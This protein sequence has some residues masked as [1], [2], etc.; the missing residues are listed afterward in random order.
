MPARV[1]RALTIALAL[2]QVSC[3]GGDSPSG[4]TPP[5]STD[6]VATTLQILAGNNQETGPGSDVAVAPSIIV[7]DQ[8]GQPFAGA[9]VTFSVDLGGGS[10]EGATV[11][12]GQNGVASVASWTLGGLLGAN[13][14][15]AS[16]GSIAPVLFNATA[17]L[18][19]ASST[20]SGSVSLPAGSSLSLGSLKVETGVTVVPVAAT[21]NFTTVAI[22]GGVHFAS[23]IAA[24]GNTVLMGWIDGSQPNFSARTTAEVMVYFDMGAFMT[25]DHRA[26]SA[27][28]SS[29]SARNDLTPLVNAI[30]QALTAGPSSVTLATTAVQ[31]ARLALAQAAIAQQPPPPSRAV[32]INGG[33]RSGI[34]VDQV[35][36]NNIIITNTYRRRVAAFVDRVSYVPE[37]GGD[38]VPSPLPGNKI[39]LSAVTSATSIIGTATDIAVG[40]MAWVPVVTEPPVPTPVFPVNARST[41]YRVTVLGPGVRN[42]NVTMNADQVAAWRRASAETAIHEFLLPLLDQVLMVDGELH[43]AGKAPIPESIL[44]SII[45]VMPN[46]V[47]ENF[48]K[49]NVKEGVIEMI[50]ALLG[51]GAFQQAVFTSFGDLMHGQ[52][53]AVPKAFDDATERWVRLL[54][55]VEGIFTAVD[56]VAVATHAANSFDAEV[57]DITVTPSK[58]ALF[59]PDVATGQFDTPILKAIVLDATGGGPAPVFAYEWSTTGNFGTLCRSVPAQCGAQFV[60]SSD[61][62]SYKPDVTKTGTDQVTVKVSFMQ[63]GVKHEVGEATG[64][65]T[66]RAGKVSLDPTP[67]T[68]FTGETQTLTATF[69]P[70]L[71]NGGTVSYRWSTTGKYGILESGLNGFETNSN[72]V[73]YNARG[74]EEGIETVEVE[75]ISTKDGVRTSL[76]KAPAAI[77][78][79]LPP[80]TLDATPPVAP[81]NATVQFVSHPGSR[82]TASSRYLWKFGDGSADVETVRDSTVAHQFTKVGVFTVLVQLKNSAGDI[83]ASTSRQVTIGHPITVTPNPA[84]AKPATPISFMART[85]APNK[86][87]P[88]RY[89]WDFGDGQTAIVNTD[90]TVQH[91][92]AAAGTFSITVVMR[93][94]TTG[95]EISRTTS[96][97]NIVAG[98]VWRLTSFVLQS[99]VIPRNPTEVWSG[100]AYNQDFEIHQTLQTRPDFGIITYE[101]EPVTV[102]GT[103]FSRGAYLVFDNTKQA[104]GLNLQYKIRA[105]AREPV[106]PPVAFDVQD[107]L[108]ATGSLT[109]GTI[110]GQ[111]VNTKLLFAPFHT[112]VQW[113]I[114]ATKNGNTLSGTII[115]VQTLWEFT[116]PP[117]PVLQNFGDIVHIWNFTATRL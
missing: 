97:A 90:S 98:G 45:D 35:G 91:A 43:R 101:S 68:L 79:K 14:L 15:K 74:S 16:C 105:L 100:Q 106:N 72:N 52:V 102:G 10:I 104:T 76:G 59:P 69:N 5:D 114:S 48:A 77:E 70:N 27:T 110:S 82:A 21:G 42:G 63:N 116:L 13:R 24:N 115:R 81:V 2:S 111:A 57:W 25:P 99:S 96:T 92:W 84:E 108:S 113:R 61:V 55:I 23:V 8:N 94:A 112:L 58:V 49:G 54:A 89:H 7:R 53:G 86:P 41:R 44:H 19:V 20:L 36:L 4:P 33:V 47:I 75:V 60:S 6:P 22:T 103:P 31:Q 109:T 73:R 26:R 39:T 11:T 62:V 29:I 28:R 65:V 37:A 117:N 80:F 51:S 107:I 87:T 64:S 95:V 38:P 18:L 66:V 56:L 93:N 34:N 85:L 3:G 32:L 1:L 78:V 67:V 9:T 50:K 83:I 17:R 88:V 71:N 12:T 46:A 30:Q 40:N